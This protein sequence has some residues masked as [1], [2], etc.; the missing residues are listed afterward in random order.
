ME[1]SAETIESAIAHHGVV[2]FG[3]EVAPQRAVCIFATAAFAET[4][5]EQGDAKQVERNQ[6]KVESAEASCDERWS[7]E[8]E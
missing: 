6:Y 8:G 3:E 4:Q 1:V 7:K 2:L 5:T